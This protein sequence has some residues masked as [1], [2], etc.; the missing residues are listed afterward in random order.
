MQLDGSVI[1]G[2]Q[3]GRHRVGSLAG[4]RDVEA[5]HWP[6]AHFGDRAPHRFAK[7]AVAKT[8]SNPSS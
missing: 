2:H 1:A 6:S 4:F 3:Q 7:Q 5:E 8:F